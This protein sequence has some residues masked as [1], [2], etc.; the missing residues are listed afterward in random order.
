MIRLM[1]LFDTIIMKYMIETNS[2]QRKI[3]QIIL[4]K[5]RVQSSEVLLEMNNT[6]DSISLVTVKRT[7]SAMVKS[8]LLNIIGAGR[9]TSYEIS[10]AG[11]VLADIN[12]TQYCQIEPDKRFGLE[13]YNFELF[14]RW[15]SD[16]FS[17]KEIERLKSATK[18]YTK[19]TKNLSASIKKRELERLIIELSWKSSKIEGNT[20]T[21]LDTEKLIKRN[22]KASGKSLE[23]TQMI[24]NHKEAF[25]YIHSHQEQ[26]NTLTSQNIMIIHSI[27]V[28]DL[29]VDSGFR[30]KPVGITGSIYQ[31]LDN[32]YQIKEA[33]DSLSNAVTKTNNPYAKALLAL[34]GIS[35]IQPFDDG[36]K[37]TAR[38]MA[39]AI[40]LAHDLAPI[41][42]RS[43]DENDYREA[44]LIFYELNSV[45]PFKYMF[46]VQYVFA[47]TNYLVK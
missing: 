15:P 28:K 32:S 31:P 25:E 40:L 36:N 9:N 10:I 11:R 19:R 2:R 7:L 35:Y 43:V 14:D 26:Y 13:K 42:Y 1:C 18:L 30:K 22:I 39:N 21:L 46:I 20:Y 38:L 29:N 3:L 37:R 34:V 12:A 6:G 45:I 17:K 44:I 24:L 4:K 8:G 41:S 27:L 16:I 5:N 33:I 23:E 47:A